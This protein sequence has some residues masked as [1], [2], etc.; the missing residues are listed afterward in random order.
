[1]TET[2]DSMTDDQIHDAGLDALVSAL[3][4]IGMAR[5]LQLVRTEHPSIRDYTAE[6][7]KWLDGL[8]LDDLIREAGALDET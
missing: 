8:T 3:G 5:F 6:R 2:A 1:M 4:P 7:H